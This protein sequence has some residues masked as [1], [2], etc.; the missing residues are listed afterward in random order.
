MGWWLNVAPARLA[1]LEHEEIDDH[2]DGIIDLYNSLVKNNAEADL[3]AKGASDAEK[4][5]QTGRIRKILTGR[6][7]VEIAREEG[8]GQVPVRASVRYALARLAIL[9]RDNQL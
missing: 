2:F 8:V 5:R 7:V 1:G 6:T 4:A 9:A 3:A